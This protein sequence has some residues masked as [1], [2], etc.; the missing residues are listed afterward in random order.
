LKPPRFGRR[1]QLHVAAPAGVG[2]CCP[3]KAS[4]STRIKALKVAVILDTCHSQGALAQTVTIPQSLSSQTLDHIK[5]GTGRVILAR[6][7]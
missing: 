2:L 4:E 6:R 3:A 7:T 1:E 5:E